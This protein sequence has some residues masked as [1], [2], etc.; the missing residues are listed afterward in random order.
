MRGL[1]V[2]ALAGC[3]GTVG[4]LSVTLVTA[5]ESTVLDSAQSLKL[6]L[7]NPHKV[8]TAQRN[9]AGFSLEL[10]LPAT[11]VDGQ[12]I[13]DAYDASGTLVA[14]GE[15]PLFPLGAIDASVAIY[16]AA[17]LSVG[18]SPV[19]LDPAR[20]DVAV[21]ALSYGAILAGG[22]DGT[23]TASDA[24]SIYNTY[25]H[26]L[27][28]GLAMPEPRSS[29]A[30]G[31][32]G[33]GLVYLFGGNDASGAATATLWAFDTNVAPNGAYND[34]GDKTGFARAGQLAVPLGSEAFLVTG[35]PAAELT[36]L[37]GAVAART[38]IAALPPAGASVVASDGMTTTIFAGAGGIVRFRGGTFDMLD[39][40]DHTGADVIALPGG[41]ALVACGTG[42]AFTVDAA[43]GSVQALA[44]VPADERTSCALAATSRHVVVAGGM[45]AS[46][47]S[48]AVDIYDAGTLAEITTAAL[49]VP[50]TAAQALALPNDQILI[51]GGVDGNAAPTATI[52]LF[53]P[54][55]LE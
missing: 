3:Q 36:G 50:R 27:V 13:A 37:D 43:A 7:T 19:S 20:R 12:L 6:V 40:A 52:E 42:G 30:L 17:P 18:A 53:T 25:D 35:T 23:G 39:T 34:Y 22:R 45:T 15:T 8:T 21:G 49:V 31:V 54:D 11:P 14:T 29:Q 1:I 41:R 26:S 10:D 48:G 33:S 46:G 28:S 24:I 47:V 51:V 5:P 38:D 9:G 55:P 44:G 4:T 16:M 32:G 2:L